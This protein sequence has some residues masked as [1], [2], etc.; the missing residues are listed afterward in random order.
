MGFAKWIK[1]LS[2]RPS[3]DLKITD[4]ARGAAREIAR[5]AARGA[6]KDAF[7]IV[8]P[9]IPRAVAQEEH[10][11]EDVPLKRWLDLPL[12]ERAPRR[13]V[14][15]V[16]LRGDTFEAVVVD[17]DA[18]RDRWRILGDSRQLPHLS[19]GMTG[20][21]EDGER[22]TATL[23]VA[24]SRTTARPLGAPPPDAPPASDEPG[25]PDGPRSQPPCGDCETYVV[26]PT[27]PGDKGPPGDGKWRLKIAKLSQRTIFQPRLR[28]VL[29]DTL[30][31]LEK[32]LE[33]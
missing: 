8:D 2:Q 33:K 18:G 29:F 31:Q 4:I 5:D 25:V 14:A 17:T 27:P 13:A 20:T 22:E 23:I 3:I 16:E 28:D 11:F 32:Q 19:A 1:D 12:D 30:S 21:A 9:T 7:Q 26:V 10:P 6:A 24:R 15:L